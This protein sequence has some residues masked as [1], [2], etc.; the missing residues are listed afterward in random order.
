MRRFMLLASTVLAACNRPQSAKPTAVRLDPHPLKT[1]IV[2]ASSED[3]VGVTGSGIVIARVSPVGPDTGYRLFDSTGQSLGP[4]MVPA[5][6]I[7]LA[8][9]DGVLHTLAPQALGITSVNHDGTAG[10]TYS[11]KEPGILRGISK[12]SADL[13]RP[14]IDGFTVVRVALDGSGQRVVVDAKGPKLQDLF[15]VKNG[16]FRDQGALPSSTTT[17]DRIIIGNGQKYR[18]QI[19]SA[20]GEFISEFGRTL[21][22]TH[23]TERQIETELSQIAQSQKLSGQYLAMVRKQLAA[24]PQAFFTAAQGFR[25]DGAGRLWVVGY[26]ADSAFADVFRDTTFVSRFSLPCPSFDGQWDL[27]GDWLAIGCGDHNPGK[28]T[29]EVQL[30]RIGSR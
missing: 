10:P 18:I 28:P 11:L 6:G 8:G 19:Y 1:A 24:A 23:P 27:K 26:E 3:P 15:G 16:V 20:K 22:A 21:P 9:D 29:G 7:W 13:M 2:I 25:V 30:Y 17:A 14:A 5:I 12:D 4:S